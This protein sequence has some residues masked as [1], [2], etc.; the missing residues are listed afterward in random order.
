MGK[1]LMYR[2]D[3]QNHLDILGILGN[4]ALPLELAQEAVRHSVASA[5]PGCGWNRSDSV[6]EVVLQIAHLQP[7]EG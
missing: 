4:S 1:S 5:V 6:R 2:C 3:L 7:Q